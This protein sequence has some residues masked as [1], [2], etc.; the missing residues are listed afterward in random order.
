MEIIKECS[1]IGNISMAEPNQTCV[2]NKAEKLDEIH[3]LIQILFY[4]TVDWV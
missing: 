4:Q 3:F 1:H 2:I